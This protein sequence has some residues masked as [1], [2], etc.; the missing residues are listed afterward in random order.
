MKSFFVVLLLSIAVLA[1][2]QPHGGT[3]A[4]TGTQPPYVTGNNY[5]QSTV[6]GG[7]YTKI[8]TCAGLAPGVVCRAD[9]LAANTTYYFV[10]TALCPS[11]APNPTESGYSNEASGKT[12]ADS[13]AVTPPVLGPPTQMTSN[14]PTV[15]VPWKLGNAVGVT[16]QVILREQSKTGKWAAQK[17]L[18]PAVTSY[19]DNSTRRG[20]LVTYRVDTYLKNGTVLASK[21]SLTLTIK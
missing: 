8:P 16:K 11:C 14:P 10:A 18:K 2:S 20:Q 6:K 3:L 7:P 21:P 17:Q 1:Q 19:L 5:F 9:G 12:Q 15:K 4:I 13:P